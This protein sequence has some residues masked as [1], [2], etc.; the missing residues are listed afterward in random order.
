[1]SD[2]NEESD[3]QETIEYNPTTIPGLMTLTSSVI[4]GIQTNL[5][6]ATEKLQLQLRDI[7][8]RLTDH[9][10]LQ[11]EATTEDNDM[12]KDEKDVPPPTTPSHPTPYILHLPASSSSSSLEAEVSRLENIPSYVFPLHVDA[13][14]NEEIARIHAILWRRM[15]DEEPETLPPKNTTQT[16]STGSKPDVIDIEEDEQNVG[17]IV[18]DL[19]RDGDSPRYLPTVE[20]ISIEDSDEEKEDTSPAYQP[21]FQTMQLVQH[22]DTAHLNSKLMKHVRVEH[23]TREEKNLCKSDFRKHTCPVCKKK[24]KS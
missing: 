12:E 20:S 10:D 13:M 17:P 21:N 5:E 16:T 15:M 22:L 2:L 4:K 9:M 1:M 14:I 11:D 24:F 7:P 3:S 18:I 19:D 6:K 8:T 23:G